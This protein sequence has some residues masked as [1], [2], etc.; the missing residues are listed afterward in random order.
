MAKHFSTHE[1]NVWLPFRFALGPVFKKWFDGLKEEKI[2]GTRCPKCHKV[3]VP[4][5]SFCP[6]CNVD[7][8][9]WV[10]VS[11]E[12]TI[13]TWVRAIKP[14][15][16]MPVATPFIAALIR[17]DDTDCSFLHLVGG[18]DA[19]DSNAVKAKIKRGTRVK[20][21]W[22]GEKKGHMFDLSHFQPI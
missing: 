11:Q 10:E 22:A 16:G 19:G 4:A 7:M 5:R 6:E 14:F 12:G 9:E 15:Y 2:W 8:D 1:L 13:E 20:A 18:L 3:L 21:V 17:L